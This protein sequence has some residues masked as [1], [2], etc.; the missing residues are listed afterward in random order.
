MSNGCNANH[1][2][3][4]STLLLAA[5]LSRRPRRRVRLPW[6]LLFWLVVLG[7][8]WFRWG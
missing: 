2:S 5:A 6:T 3:V 1:S 8:T 7:Y 4:G